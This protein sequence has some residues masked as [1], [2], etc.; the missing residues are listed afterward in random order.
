MVENDWKMARLDKPSNPTVTSEGQ[1]NEEKRTYPSLVGNM[2]FDSC[3]IVALI[4]FLASGRLGRRFG[5]IEEI[6]PTQD[7][8]R[9]KLI[10]A[11]TINDDEE[12]SI[13]CK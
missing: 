1:I 5:Q 12:D 6:F 7:S 4:F 10:R 13:S 2:I 9:R 8:A 11:L 3:Q